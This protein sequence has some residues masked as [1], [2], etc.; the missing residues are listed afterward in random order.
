MGDGLSSYR[1]GVISA[2]NALALAAGVRV[3]MPA[4]EA[5]SLLLRRPA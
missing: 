2:A 4:A 1:D 5:A 3:G